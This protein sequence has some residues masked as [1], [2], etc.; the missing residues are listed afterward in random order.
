[1]LAPLA[2]LQIG[3]MLKNLGIRN[4]EKKVPYVLS[5]QSGSCRVH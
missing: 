2:Q 5:G 4:L 3:I 1:M